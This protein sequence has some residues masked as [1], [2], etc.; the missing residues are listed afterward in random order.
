ML[1]LGH[2]AGG[3]VGA[4]DLLGA[5]T[6]ALD[7]GRLRGA[8]RAALPGGGPPRPGARCAARHGLAGGR[9]PLRGELPLLSAAAAPARA[10]PAAP[11]RRAGR[12]ACCAS[13]SPCTRRAGRRRTASPSSR[14]P[15]VPVLVVQGER[16]PFGRPE[17]APGREVVLL[18]GD[19]S[20]K[21]DAPGS[22]RRRDGVARDG[23]PLTGATFAPVRR[24]RSA[25]A[26]SISS[27]RRPALQ[28][29]CR[30]LSARVEHGRQPLAL[31]QGRDAA[32]DVAGGP[33]GRRHLGHR[34]CFRRT[35]AASA[36]RSSSPPTGTT[37]SPGPRPPR[38]PAS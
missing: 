8:R 16:D 12:R 2:G 10:W 26:S 29:T 32:R 5:T 11:R 31:A 9:R 28:N 33:L 4:P 20:L 37:R 23:H 30:S 36:L 21:S 18:R 15:T 35:A 24:T 38:R 27:P 7:V 19:H 34:A 1:L 14:A 3:G 22:A 25:G 17:P 13:R 6:A